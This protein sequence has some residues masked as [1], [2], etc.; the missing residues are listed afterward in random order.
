MKR[1]TS[2]AGLTPWAEL[3]AELARAEARHRDLSPDEYRQLVHDRGRP[4]VQ[5]LADARKTNQERRARV[6]RHP[7]LAERLQE[8]LGLSR[9]S[10]WNGWVPPAT[11]PEVGARVGRDRAGNRSWSADPGVPVANASPRRAALVLICREAAS[12]AQAA[13]REEEP[14]AV[15]GAS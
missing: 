6:L 4:A 12:R 11:D 9:A 8:L 13:A 1:Q 14:E 2:K 10:D 15:R 3:Y 7:D 5:M